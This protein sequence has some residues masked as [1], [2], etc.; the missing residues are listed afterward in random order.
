MTPR[1]LAAGVAGSLALLSALHVVWVFSSWPLA[2]RSQF[3]EAV[4]G[5]DPDEAPSTAAT[6]AVAGLLGA[7]SLLVARCGGQRRPGRTALVGTRIVAA[8][9]LARAAGGFVV[10]GNRL[11]SAPPR[12][13]RLDLTVYS[14]LC[15]ILGA[16]AAGVAAGAERT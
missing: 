13:R 16:G 14:P 11:G 4:L 8:V 3:A 12:F 2:D 7:S 9:L 1:P 15:L 6:W 10:S 5:T